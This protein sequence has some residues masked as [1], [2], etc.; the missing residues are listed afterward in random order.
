MTK[1][2]ILNI[3][4]IENL[5]YFNELYMKKKGKIT[6]FINLYMDLIKT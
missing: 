5:N 2:T 4:S 6:V 1:K 3:K